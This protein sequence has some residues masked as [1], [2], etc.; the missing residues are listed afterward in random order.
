MEKLC[1]YKIIRGILV[2]K[3]LHMLIEEGT[4]YQITQVIQ[5]N[6]NSAETMTITTNN[7]I[8]IQFLLGENKGRGSMPVEYFTYLLNKSRLSL[9]PNKRM[10]LNVDHD[11]EQ[12]G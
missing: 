7:G 9:I 5:T 4:K 8:T 1:M 10:M 2:R 6:F 12:I 3:E 11:E